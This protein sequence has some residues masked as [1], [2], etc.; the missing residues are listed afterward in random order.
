MA[1]LAELEMAVS[2]AMEVGCKNLIRL[3]WT[4]TYP[5]KPENINISTIPH[6][7]H[8]FDVEVGLSDHTMGV[9]FAVASIALGALV[10]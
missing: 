1:T 10:I 7:K 2:T 6:L 3:K 5:S 8:L 4:S 9:R